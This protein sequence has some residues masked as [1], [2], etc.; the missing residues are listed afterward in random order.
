MG[1]ATEKA[2]VNAD[3]WSSNDLAQVVVCKSNPTKSEYDLFDLAVLVVNTSGNSESG[4]ANKCLVTRRRDTQ[5]RISGVVSSS[6]PLIHAR[7][8]SLVIRGRSDT[9]DR[10]SG[11]IG[12]TK[13]QKATCL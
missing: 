6:R 10:R 5:V 8:P 12:V 2:A 3:I 9:P 7:A 11:V 4:K 1:L 13:E